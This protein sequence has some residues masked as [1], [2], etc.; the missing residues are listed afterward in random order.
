METLHQE[1]S[2]PRQL[3]DRTE[4]ARGLNPCKQ[5]RKVPM[6]GMAIGILAFMKSGIMMTGYRKS[7]W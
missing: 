1:V 6:R 3:L 2:K 5:R 4:V 7:P